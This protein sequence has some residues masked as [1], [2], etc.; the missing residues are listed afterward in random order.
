MNTHIKVKVIKGILVVIVW[1][2]YLSWMSFNLNK[3]TSI[4]LAMPQRVAADVAI[5]V[6]GQ[7]AAWSTK[8]TPSET[9]APFKETYPRILA[10]YADSSFSHALIEPK[11]LTE[12]S[13]PVSPKVIVEYADSSFSQSLQ[14]PDSLA[15]E[16]VPV[17]PRIVVEYADSSFS[18]S[19]QNPDGLKTVAKRVS[20]RIIVEYADSAL[21][22]GFAPPSFAPLDGKTP[23]E[24]STSSS[25]TLSLDEGLNMISLPLK[26]QKP[27]TARSFAEEL[28][29]TVVIRYDTKQDEFLPFVPDVFEGDGFPIEGGQG[30]IVNLL[31]PKEIVITGTAWSNAP[32]KPIQTS[33]LK[34]NPHWAFVVCGAIYDGNR[35]AQNSE[36]TVTAEN[37]RTSEIAEAKIGQLENGRYTTAF[38]DLGRKEVVELG[39][40]LGVYFRDTAKGMVSKP[41]IH[42]ITT[43]DIVKSYIEVNLRMKNLV[44]HKNA[45]LQNYPNPFNP[46]TWI[47][48]QLAQD[49]NVTISIYNVSG[50]LVRT[51]NLGYREAGLYLSKGLAAYWDGRTEMEEQTAS[52]IYFYTIRV[53]DFRATRRMVII[54]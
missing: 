17:S 45:L 14:N 54:R 37:L 6:E 18:Q 2:A 50:Q 52:G 48:F 20:S 8:L 42:T 26:Q 22:L 15:K 1:V 34:I 39:D 10:E 24:P 33:P 19:L 31:E 53:G 16:T 28:G 3:N 23:V 40:S 49:G 30:Y 35:I 7:D 9:L 36:L 5:E 13:K 44:P 43:L 38:V 41:V 47:P 11:E 32:S 12:P 29:A 4:S 25:F 27:L 46:E 21:S 51:L